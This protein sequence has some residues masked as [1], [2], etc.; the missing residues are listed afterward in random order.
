MDNET[1]YYEI[2]TLTGLSFK[3]KL[4]KNPI[5]NEF[6]PHIWHRHQVSPEEAV[7]AYFN[8][9]ENR[10]NIKH[11]RYEG[12]SKEDDIYIYYMYL[13]KNNKKIMVIT[14]FRP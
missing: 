13:S 3:F 1:R 11:K 8:K 10:W 12:Y 5:N 4:D 6:E 7:L 14:A 9:I 2:H